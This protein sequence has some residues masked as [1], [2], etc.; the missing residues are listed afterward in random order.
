V[1]FLSL[2][3]V[4]SLLVTE[5]K[6]LDTK[7]AFLSL[8]NVGSLLVTEYKVL[9]PKWLCTLLNTKV[10]FLSLINVGSNC[11]CLRV[12]SSFSFSVPDC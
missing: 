9:I 1:A 12:Y 4:G 6:V 5:F 7:V 2:I 11:Y 3:N 8:I 10:T